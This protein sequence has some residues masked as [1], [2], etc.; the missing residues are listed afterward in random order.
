MDYT[1]NS[2]SVIF[3]KDT[4]IVQDVEGKNSSGEVVLTNGVASYDFANNISSTANVQINTVDQKVA[5]LDSWTKEE[6]QNTSSYISNDVSVSLNNAITAVDDKVGKLNV[7]TTISVEGLCTAIDTKTNYL[8]G[9]ISDDI[10]TSIDAANAAFTEFKLCTETSAANLTT[11]IDGIK[12]DVKGGVNY[13]GHLKLNV[14][15]D[16]QDLSTYVS[17]LHGGSY[18]G[19]TITIPDDVAAAELNNGWMYYVSLTGDDISSYTTKDGITF[20][21][22]N[23]IIVHAHNVEGDASGLSSVTLSNL[24]RG[25]IDIVQVTDSDLV[26]FKDLNAALTGDIEGELGGISAAVTSE[27]K[28]TSAWVTETV[29]T[30]STSLSTDYSEKFNLADAERSRLC[31][32]LSD[33]LI[34]EIAAREA[35]S[36]A[37]NDKI[38][39]ISTTTIPEIKVALQEEVDARATE[40]AVINEKV[41]AKVIVNT[42]PLVG[43]STSQNIEQLKINRMTAA[44]YAQLVAE[45][46]VSENELY[47]ITDAEM[48]A[49]GKKILSVGTPENPLDA[50][51]KS[52]VDTAVDNVVKK[53]DGISTATGDEFKKTSSY[54]DGISNVLSNKVKDDY[55]LTAVGKFAQISVQS[56]AN[57]SNMQANTA[58]VYQLTANEETAAHITAGNITATDINTTKL[59]VHNSEVALSTGDT[60]INVTTQRGL[61]DFLVNGTSLYETIDTSTVNVLTSARDYSNTLC[62]KISSTTNERIAAALTDAKSYTDELSAAIDNKLTATSS[63]INA[64]DAVASANAY[65]QVK[66]DLHSELDSANRLKLYIGE[67]TFADY[68]LHNVLQNAVLQDTNDGQKAIVFTWNTEPGVENTTSVLVQDLIDTYNGDGTYIK[69]SSDSTTF[70]LDFNALSNALG[71]GQLSTR[72]SNIETSCAGFDGRLTALEADN[73]TNKDNIRTLS[74]SLT[75]ADTGIN[76]MLTSHGNSIVSLQSD[77]ASINSIINDIRSGSTNSIQSLT[78]EISA[79]IEPNLKDLNVAKAQ[80][81][82]NVGTVNTTINEHGTK[83]GTIEQRIATIDSTLEVAGRSID[84]AAASI[85]TI[86]I[87]VQSADNKIDQISTNY[88]PISMLTDYASANSVYRKT[89]TSSSIEIQNAFTDL[90]NT[91][92]NVATADSIFAKRDE[93]A[94]NHYSKTEVDNKFVT[95]TAAGST[96]ETAANVDNLINSI[97]NQLVSVN[98]VDKI[99]ESTTELSTAVN[100]LIDSFNSVLSV[101]KTIAKN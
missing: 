10:T 45:D 91:Y 62:G 76:A 19:D 92:Y 59:Y 17:F 11:A 95:Q 8:S 71:V 25:N 67:K 42:Y 39:E 5:A 77:V 50:A 7:N 23:Y 46:K 36:T 28:T 20:V 90:T 16:P 37:T 40:D 27:F 53:A 33:A 41:D 1:Q 85:E 87:N 35:Y 82:T 80:L 34:A 32:A 74:N 88:A 21:P 12:A 55:A 54:I 86:K 26:R 58:S 51:N 100:T 89:E 24:N 22:G 14:F 61:Q 66:N 30:V 18:Q 57:F 29:H 75:A 2:N 9:I 65:G 68:K 13:K 31:T 79:V 97:K 47:S 94:V 48:N 6:F 70:Y 93:I 43:D 69:L 63:Y 49:Y 64:Q 60:A 96:Y 44:Q 15:S 83:L 81:C 4:D 52:Y 98:T 3:L 38:D 84:Q 101:L 72:A 78:N 73:A 99:N 56:N